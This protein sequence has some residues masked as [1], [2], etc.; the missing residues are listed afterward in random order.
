MNEVDDAATSTQELLWVAGM[1]LFILLVNLFT[2]SRS[3]TVWSDEVMFTEPAANVVLGKGLTS[4][5]W[6]RLTPETTWAGNAPLHTWLLVPWIKVFG[7]TP[8]VVRAV[9]FMYVGLAA[10]LLWWA[11]RTS[12]LV[13]LPL[14][15]VGLVVVILFD[16]AVSFSY[17]S[18]RYDALGMLLAAMVAATVAARPSLRFA[19]SCLVPIGI[20]VPF[21]GLQLV[22]Y[23]IVVSLVSFAV[24]GPRTLRLSIPLGLGVAMGGVLLYATLLKLGNWD[25]FVLSVRGF[26]GTD[27]AIS[28]YVTRLLDSFRALGTDPLLLLVIVVLLLG[29]LSVQLRNANWRRFDVMALILVI[30][31]PT[32]VGFSGRFPNYYLWMISIPGIIAA[33]QVCE[34]F[35]RGDARLRRLSWAVGALLVIGAMSGLPARLAVTMIEWSRRDYEP[36]E[37]LVSR[38]VKG[39]DVIFADWQA[40]YA[41][42]RVGATVYYPAYRM[43]PHEKA[44]LTKLIVAPEDFQRIIITLGGNWHE[45]GALHSAPYGLGAKLYNLRI[46]A[47]GPGN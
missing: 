42:A 20:L 7:L 17:R 28:S 14:L 13:T 22:P 34:R 15:R 6:P 36:V 24:F 3:P 31:V 45:V 32:I 10:F 30:A 27:Q 4:T 44:A 25:A 43:N 12:R 47:I 16:T 2:A 29:V 37:A 18:G 1:I 40:F 8:T 11:V 23:A 26:R 46:Y 9:G 35:R 41:L 33:F 5:A 39:D 21:T 38:A 19:F